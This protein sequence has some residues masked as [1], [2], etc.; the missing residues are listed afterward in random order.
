M[1]NVIYGLSCACHPERG[2]RYVGQTIQ[3]IETRIYKHKWAARSGKTWVVA[4]WIRKHGEENL[5]YEV[6]EALP[7][8]EG[9]GEAEEKWIAHLGTMTEHGGCNTTPGGDQ[10]SGYCHPPGAMSRTPRKH[11]KEALKKIRESRKKQ[12]GEQVGSA[13]LT[14]ADVSDIL[15][16][17]WNGAKAID[18]AKAFDVDV[19]NISSITSGKTWPHVP[20]PIGPRR[21]SPTGHF[22]QGSIPRN[23]KLN[24]EQVLSIRQ[25]FSEGESARSLSSQY[26]ITE[27]NL[28]YIIQGTTWRNVPGANPEAFKKVKT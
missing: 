18:L 16:Q 15:F 3:G 14:E 26:D 10:P 11:T 20:R 27:T 25:R 5:R 8:K 6:L 24:A 4:K 22:P 17:H 12:L 1:K 19:A 13:K 28:R 21:Y 9:L 2:V 7:T 23:A